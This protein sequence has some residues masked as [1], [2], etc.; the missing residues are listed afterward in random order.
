MNVLGIGRNETGLKYFRPGTLVS[1]KN[2]LGDRS[3]QVGPTASVCTFVVVGEHPAAV[4]FL[5]RGVRLRERW[6]GRQLASRRQPRRRN[7]GAWW[8]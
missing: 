1:S 3:G 4:R 7:A 6:R 2:D 5:R 8:W